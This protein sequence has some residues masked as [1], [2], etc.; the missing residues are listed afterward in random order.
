MAN[1]TSSEGQKW[2]STTLI[3]SESGTVRTTSANTTGAGYS[4]DEGME[5]RHGSNH[6][7]LEQWVDLES[8]NHR[9]I[10]TIRSPKTEYSVDSS[11][12]AGG[13]NDLAQQM[14][15]LSASRENHLQG[16]N[17]GNPSIDT[18]LG[19]T[20]HLTLR[21]YRKLSKNI[22]DLPH[23]KTGA[24]TLIYVYDG[25]NLDD[26]GGMSTGDMSLRSNTVPVTEGPLKLNTWHHAAI[27]YK[28]STKRLS[29]FLDG[30]EVAHEILDNEFDWGPNGLQDVSDGQDV[31]DADPTNQSHQKGPEINLCVAVDTLD[32]KFTAR[33]KYD[34]SGYELPLN[35]HQGFGIDGPP[36]QSINP[37]DGSIMPS[38]ALQIENQLGFDGSVFAHWNVQQNFINYDKLN[39][40]NAYG[41]GPYTLNSTDTWHAYYSGNP[42]ILT[43]V[44]SINITVDELKTFLTARYE[45][46]INHAN[47]DY[48]ITPMN[49]K[50]NI[51]PTL[52]GDP[53]S[54]RQNDYRSLKANSAMAINKN[55][56]LQIGGYGSIYFVNSY[57]VNNHT[58]TKPWV[59]ANAYP[60]DHTGP[61]MID[62]WW[63]VDH[64]DHDDDGSTFST[65][66][67]FRP[68]PNNDGYLG[69]IFRLGEI[70]ASDTMSPD[71]N[72]KG[73]HLRVGVYHVDNSNN[74]YWYLKWQEEMFYSHTC[75]LFTTVS[76]SADSSA[77][78]AGVTDYWG[79]QLGY[80]DT[81]LPG[82]NGSAGNMF[83]HSIQIPFAFTDIAGNV[84]SDRT[85]GSH[86]DVA[87]AYGYTSEPEWWYHP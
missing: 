66:Q 36:Y 81:V 17:T 7:S 6:P 54:E 30:S 41:T 73:S 82:K 13:S 28:A 76:G 68:S 12:D 58:D 27:V 72:Q 64:T 9:H 2:P 85:S 53:I 32:V 1:N 84:S 55:D 31:A 71:S 83:N 34:S 45:N 14:I 67:W 61:L 51:H 25:Y 80:D 24:G 56:Q 65:S 20:R 19:K 63:G 74:A 40:L 69:E 5:V 87:E 70:H 23:R 38:S 37:V 79:N 26:Q 50:F 47:N 42:G 75:R 86:T 4:Y 18:G 78:A 35:N 3:S 60:S 29:L 8:F 33:A 21:G 52:N 39:A 10:L 59:F 77:P 46:V 62:M 43:N 15:V 16:Y 44:P 57:A 49:R 48:H 11:G 22:N